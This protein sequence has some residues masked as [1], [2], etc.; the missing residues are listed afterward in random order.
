MEKQAIMRASQD[1][2]KKKWK[3]VVVFSNPSKK[4]TSKLQN[5]AMV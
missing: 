1:Q 2:K 5:N 4:K 3:A